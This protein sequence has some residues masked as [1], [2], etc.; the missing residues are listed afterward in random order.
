MKKKFSV[1]AIAILGLLAVIAGPAAA[2][3]KPMLWEKELFSYK[4]FPPMQAPET[5]NLDGILKQMQAA[6]HPSS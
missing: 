6:G 3:Q 4:E 2:Q 1:T 5:Y